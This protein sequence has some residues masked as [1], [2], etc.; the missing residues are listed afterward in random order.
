MKHPP[1]HLRINKAVDRFAL[2]EAIRR[3]EKLGNL[4]EY[5]YY[6]LGGPYLEEFR[7]LYEFYPE[8]DMF[9]I[10]QD[11][12]TYKRQKFHLPCG[13]LHLENM[14]V[15]SFLARYDSGGKKSIVW[16]DYTGLEYSDF[17][18]FMLLLTRVAE[19]SMVKI[20]L[21]AEPRD[22]FNKGEEFRKKFSAIM[23]RP[24]EDPPPMVHDFAYLL[25]EMLQISSQKALPAD[26]PIKFQPVSSFYYS[27][28]TN[29][30]TLTGVIWPRREKTAVK[31][32]FKGWKF[33]NLTW[34]EP[35]LIDIPTLSTKERLCLEGF[36]PCLKSPGKTLRKA[37]GYLIDEDVPITE[38]KLKQYADF[39]RY[40]PYF[41]RG[42]P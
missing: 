21:R 5:N 36:L 29:M 4:N 15:K 41:L 3:L 2:I 1:Y 28:G 35:R 37:L 13:T 17:E 40:S 38:A 14:D 10:E 16:L 31:Q 20:T 18:D 23:P 26:V 25:Q 30:Y 22:Y 8:I 42:I 33:A 39:H 32:V 12:E 11:E 7:L 9:S 6:G 24:S 27:D 19:K 34:S